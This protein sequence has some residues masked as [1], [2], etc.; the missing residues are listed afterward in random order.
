MEEGAIAGGL[1]R[2]KKLK[3]RNRR[4]ARGEVGDEN[5]CLFLSRASQCF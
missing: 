5:F 3:K 2:L 4:L 1:W